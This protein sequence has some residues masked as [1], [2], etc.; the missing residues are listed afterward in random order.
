MRR[1]NIEM[2]S[3][4]EGSRKLNLETITF[5]RRFQQHFVPCFQFLTK[6]QNLA[7]VTSRMNKEAFVFLNILKINIS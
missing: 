7:R 6:C 3:M 2:V 4:N 5:T 1:Q